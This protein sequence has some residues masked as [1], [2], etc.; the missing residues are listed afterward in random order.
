MEF[1]RSELQAQL[2]LMKSCSSTPVNEDASNKILFTEEGIINNSRGRLITFLQGSYDFEGQF[3]IDNLL[4]IVKNISGETIDLSMEKEGDLKISSGK[5]KMTL[6]SDELPEEGPTSVRYMQE[7]ISGL[8][9]DKKFTKLPTNFIDGIGKVLRC[10]ST[11]KNH[12]FLCNINVQG[13]D[14][15]ASDNFKIGHYVL[16]K[17]FPVKFLIDTYNIQPIV[18]FAPKSYFLLEDKIIF[19]RGQDYQICV[20]SK[21][22]YPDFME[23]LS[24]KSKYEIELPEGIKGALYLAQQ[25]PGK[26]IDRQVILKQEKFKLTLS[27]KAQTGW[28]RQN[29]PMKKQQDISFAMNLNVLT[30]LVSDLGTSIEIQETNTGKI[31]KDGFTFLFPIE[32]G[33]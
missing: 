12:N 32:I 1:N 20:I 2:E 7:T 33:E 26:D 3:L 11:D 15:I 9:K 17:E 18:S 4:N 6:K 23:I 24:H 14:L 19:K 8:L 30:E 10:A 28:F 13:S 22:D 5:T 27:C 25:I 31:S 21:E 29:F 16:D